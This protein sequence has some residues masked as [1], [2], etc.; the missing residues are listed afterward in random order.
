[1]SEARAILRCVEWMQRHREPV[2]ERMWDAI[3]DIAAHSE[4]DFRAKLRAW[5]MLADRVDPVPKP[6][7]Q[8]VVQGDLHVAW[9]LPSSPSPTALAPSSLP[10]T[11]PLPANGH[12]PASPSVTDDLESL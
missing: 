9:Q 1:M 6:L 4:A 11:T 12:G 3:Y 5:E 8:A 2:D 7:I 10:S